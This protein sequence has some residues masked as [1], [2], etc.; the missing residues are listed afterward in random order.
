MTIMKKLFSLAALLMVCGAASAQADKTQSASGTTQDT[1]NVTK[2]DKISQRNPVGNSNQP[3][4]KAYI[5]NDDKSHKK[6]KSKAPARNEKA[7]ENKN[8]PDPIA[9]AK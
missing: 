8:N 5:K 7:K 6:A 3:Q 1:V 9:P 4:D 2:M